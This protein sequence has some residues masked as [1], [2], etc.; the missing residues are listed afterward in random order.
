VVA[1][2]KSEAW[3]I[4]GALPDW[5]KRISISG[6][7]RVRGEGD[8]FPRGNVVN[9][10]PYLNWV[11]INN[12]GGFSK[13]GQAAFLNT[14]VDHYCSGVCAWLSTRNSI[15]DGVSDHASRPVLSSIRTPPTRCW[16]N[17]AAATRPTS[18]WPI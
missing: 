14:S 10:Y 7:M 3:G 9:S 6:D 8:V 2:A 15:R 18:I 16:D 12:A 4:P 11:A 1:E 13:A 17:T 5:I